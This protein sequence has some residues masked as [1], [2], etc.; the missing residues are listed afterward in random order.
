MKKYFII[1]ALINL[2]VGC[3]QSKKRT[4][5]YN[6][7]PSSV[8]TQTRLDTIKKYCSG[9]PENTEFAFTIIQNDSVYHFGIKKTNGIYNQIENSKSIFEIGSITK[10]FTGLLLVDAEN[11]GLLNIKDL[12]QNFFDNKLRQSSLNDTAITILNLAHHNSGLPRETEYTMKMLRESPYDSWSGFDS[13][14]FLKFLENEMNLSSTP[15][16]KW[17]YSNIGYGLLT[18]I[19]LKQSGRGFE[20]LLQERICARYDLNYTTSDTNKIKEIEVIGLKPNGQDAPHWDS[21]KLLGASGV[22]S[23]SVDMTVFAKACMNDDSLFVSQAK[24]LF[25]VNDIYSVSLGWAVQYYQGETYYVANGGTP[26]YMATIT[27][28]PNKNNAVIILSNVSCYH[29]KMLGMIGLN[30]QLML[31]IE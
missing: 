27:I 30:S 29:E 14:E 8:F 3:N 28:N 24:Q 25:Y 4:E 1:V 11:Q 15:G 12:I 9:L 26:G 7:T 21:G 31:T 5:E 18:N 19:I 16:V 22:L 23:N 20:R 17:E 10:A 6:L 13:I 2:F